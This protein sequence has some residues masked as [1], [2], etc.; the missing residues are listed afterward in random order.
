MS[1]FWHKLV[2]FASLFVAGVKSGITTVQGTVIKWRNVSINSISDVSKSVHVFQWSISLQTVHGCCC[3]FNL[4]DHTRLCIASSQCELY[5][6]HQWRGR[7]PPTASCARS[8]YAPEGT[9]SAPTTSPS[10]SSSIHER[11]LAAQTDVC[12]VRDWGSVE[13]PHRP[14]RPVIY[15]CIMRK[16]NDYLLSLRRRHR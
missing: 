2:H 15:L 10:S 1:Q 3:E 7:R 13:T 14:H 16:H 8:N 9:G 12:G 4:I 5:M 6:S 11:P